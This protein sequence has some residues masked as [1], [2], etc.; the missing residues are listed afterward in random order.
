M[1]LKSF[2]RKYLDSIQLPMGTIG[3]LGECMEA[4][5]RQQL[6]EQ[7]K[8]E[9][10]KALR[11]QAMIQSAESSNR[12]EGVEVSVDRLK[13]LVLGR[14]KPRSRSEEEI[15]GY[16]RA[17]EI[18][19]SKH[20]TLEMNPKIITHLH[21]LAQEGAGDAGLWKTK[22]NEI[23][24]FD[25]FGQRSVRFVP[26]SAK[27][28]VSAMENLCESYNNE[29]KSSQLPTLIISSLFILD[30]LCIHPFRD[31]NGRVSRL[32]SLL[33]LYQSGFNVGKYVSLERIVEENKESYYEALKISSEGWHHQKH[34]SLPWINFCLSILRQAYKEM[35]ENVERSS[36]LISGKGE[37]VEA[38]V[39][40]QIGSFSL[41]EIQQC[42]PNVSTQMIKKI[43]NDFKKEKKVILAG[44]GRGARWRV[45]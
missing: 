12:I 30:F 5:G 17:L 29:M 38:A 11:D 35:T 1:S 19:H 13:P 43:L 15:R 9:S 7:R 2:K 45:K 28:K 31:G 23:I 41:R 26:L 6:W 33:S 20:Q 34:D 37:L 18:I 3:L 24:E 39:L 44:R 42:C 27:D 40:R 21:K 14:T 16:R 36:R 10:L 8:P 22:N 25:H 4:K 32:L